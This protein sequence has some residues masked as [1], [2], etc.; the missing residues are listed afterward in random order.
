MGGQILYGREFK[1]AEI[2]SH[3][4][5]AVVN[6]RFAA[7]F[8]APVDIVGRQLTTEDT[9]P[10][11]I[12]GVVKGIEY[13]TDPTLVKPFQVFVPPTTPGIFPRPPSWLVLMALRNITSLPSATRYGQPTRECLCSV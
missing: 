12:V 1:D 13:E 7:A 4:R 9:P 5:V 8:G 10:W 11:K 6:E 2:R 3:A